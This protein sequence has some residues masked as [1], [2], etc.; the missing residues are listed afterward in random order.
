MDNLKWSE[1]DFTKI[2]Y[3]DL[4]R[5]L[6]LYSFYYLLAINFLFIKISSLANLILASDNHS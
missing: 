4:V 2:P 3:D 1:Y 5:V 6:L